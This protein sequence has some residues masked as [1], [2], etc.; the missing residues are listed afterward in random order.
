MIRSHKIA[1]YAENDLA[2][3]NSKTTEGVLRYRCEDVVCVIDS[4]TAGQDVADVLGVG[5][6][7]RVP[8]VP[9]LAAALALAP[10]TL[11]VGF[12]PT[13]SELPA[14]VRAAVHAA[15]SAGLHVISGLHGFLGRDPELVRLAEERGVTL[16]DVRKPP[17]SS[18]LPRYLPRR[19]GSKVLLTV[20]SDMYIGKMTAALELHAAMRRRGVSSEV[21]ATGQIGM[22]ITH[23]GLPA[24][25]IVSDFLS[26]HVDHA[27]QEAAERSDWVLVEGQASLNNPAASAVTL[28]L[29]HGALPDYMVLCHRAGATHLRHYA[30]C[31]IP[32]LSELV[33]MNETAVNWLHPL[34][35]A[36]VAG[37]A[38]NTAGLDEAAA[39]EAVD[40]A[41][42][43]TGLPATDVLRF[44][45]DPLID[46]L[47]GETSSA[48]VRVRAERR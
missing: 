19:P 23:S 31:P 43:E 29:Q 32:P 28:G 34:K 21:L 35:A 26:G 16:W 11:L 18:L 12:E 10:D 39:R 7:R 37:I 25:A 9:D 22:M 46:A 4:R 40:A 14:H 3:Q 38:L 6:P 48:G 15:V 30:N 42:D 44:G 20:G 17:E 8:V 13:H 2:W 1:I 27:V 47:L 45:T 33:E 24:D 5:L 41:A 36:K